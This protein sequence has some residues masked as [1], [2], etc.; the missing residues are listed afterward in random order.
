MCGDTVSSTA[1][2]VA[3]W[4]N[5]THRH[6]PPTR[7][8]LVDIVHN[9]GVSSASEVSEVC[10]VHVWRTADPHAHA[11]MS[12][13]SVYTHAQTNSYTQWIHTHG[14]TRR[15]TDTQTHVHL[16]THGHTQGDTPPISNNAVSN[17]P[18]KGF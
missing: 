18:K 3:H 11:R 6:G 8:M 17:S 2:L 14:K 1:H 4:T 5:N 12:F 16:H 9:R 10:H 7:M 15:H 13:L